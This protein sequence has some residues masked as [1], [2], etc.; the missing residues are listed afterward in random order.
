MKRKLF[1]GLILVTALWIGLGS[2][3]LSGRWAEGPASAETVYYLSKRSARIESRTVKV[4]GG[5]EGLF[6]AWRNLS[7]LPSCVVLTHFSVESVPEMSP[8]PYITIGI[9][10][11]IQPYIAEDQTAL[12]ET[13]SQTIQDHYGKATVTITVADSV[14]G[15]IPVYEERADDLSMD[16]LV[17][18]E[19]NPV[20]TIYYFSEETGQIE[21]VVQEIPGG[22]E[23]VFQKWRELS[24]LPADIALERFE[25]TA[26]YTDEITQG[27]SRMYQYTPIE[28]IIE[29]E[30]SADSLPHIGPE[31]AIRWETL[32]RTAREKHA[33]EDCKATVTITA[34][35]E[36]VY[37]GS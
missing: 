13:L 9:S 21:T 33:R 11:E 35:E 24:G 17:I 20:E 31:D 28:P 1:A 36:L 8:Y 29:I 19:E 26:G 18:I 3:L 12:W 34:G 25:V 16:S 7:G 27:S 10:E 4:R 5:E 2:G 32:A 30:L 22:N 6:R 37:F 23:A 15:E 14:L